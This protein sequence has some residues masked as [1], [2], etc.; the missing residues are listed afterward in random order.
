MDNKYQSRFNPES[1]EDKMRV[2]KKL[3]R[4]LQNHPKLKENQLVQDEIVGL[5]WAIRELEGQQGAP[6]QAVEP[7]VEE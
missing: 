5:D 1:T 6:A 4:W 2:L 7:N 3:L